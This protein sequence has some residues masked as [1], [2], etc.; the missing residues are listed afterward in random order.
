[1]VFLSLPSSPKCKFYDF[2]P[3]VR[4]ECH[5]NNFPTPLKVYCDF[6]WEPLVGYSNANPFIGSASM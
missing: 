6:S 5:F 2:A 1:M 4:L 3:Q